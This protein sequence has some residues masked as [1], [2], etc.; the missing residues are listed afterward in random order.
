MPYKFHNINTFTCVFD[1][2]FHDTNIGIYTP[3]VLYLLLYIDRTSSIYYVCI[4]RNVFMY[5]YVTNMSYFGYKI[6]RKCHGSHEI[7]SYVVCCITHRHR[8]HQ[9]RKK[10][11]TKDTQA[12]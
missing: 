2:I 1:I 6:F 5:I 4:H 10:K 9:K 8:H 7:N 3:Y 12:A 11:I